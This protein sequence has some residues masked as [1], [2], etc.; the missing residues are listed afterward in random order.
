MHA[1]TVSDLPHASNI[2]REIAELSRERPGITEADLRAEGFTKDEIAKH[3][4]EAA[5]MLRA[6]ENARGA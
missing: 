2:A 4:T 1:S 3:A 6:A 5:E